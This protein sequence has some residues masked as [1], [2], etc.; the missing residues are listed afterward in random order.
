VFCRSRHVAQFVLSIWGMEVTMRGTCSE[1][2][3]YF[4]L[5]TLYFIAQY[6]HFLKGKSPLRTMMR[7][8]GWA[9]VNRELFS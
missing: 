8:W 3:G 2:A 7:C 6:S 5:S 1:S 9:G 4:P